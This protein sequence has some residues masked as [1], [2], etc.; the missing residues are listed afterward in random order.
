MAD[1]T[2][3]FESALLETGWA[4]EVRISVRDGAI[5]AIDVGVRRATHEAAN[6]PALPGLPNL[7]SHAFQRG[8]AGL[9]EHRGASADSFW[10]WREVMYRFLEQLGP[11]EVQAIAA[12]AYAEMLEAGFTRV[13]EFHYLHHD[14]DGRA[15]SNPAEM[16]VRIAAAAAEAGLGLT[17]L[18]VFY[19]HS[20]FGGLPPTDGQARFIHDVDGFA[21]LFEASRAA[22]AGLDG[23]VVGVAPHSLR[24]ATPQQIHTL[25]ELAGDAPIHIHIAEQ[26]KEV[27]DCQAWSGARPVEWLLANLD[28]GPQWC[29]VHATHI[30]PDE[31]AGI[32][33]SG[34]VAG[35]CPITEANLGDGLFPAMEF[36]AQGGRLG[37]GSDSNVLIDA[38]EELRLLEYGQRLSRRS[39]NVL[40]AEAGG[41]TGAA[42]YQAALAGGAQAL[43]VEVGLKVGMSADIVS[44]ASDHPVIA[45]RAG[46]AILDSYIFAGRRDL[47]DGV[48]RAGAKLVTSGRHRSREEISAR[49]RQVLVKVL[50]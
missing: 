18:P 29:L 23:A 47:I 44:L 42:L 50:S 4:R 31:T 37:V 32:A 11:D 48:W 3:W 25:A 6:G 33:R 36:R 15:F 24:A 1:E 30:T 13:G 16:A 7:H 39:R 46:D 19:A 34:A 28:V 35:L 43:G 26:A 14:L 40:A 2:I 49:Y 10:T 12:Q 41:S 21:R 9:A 20:G 27:A 22:V 17:L 8:M 5:A 38:A 45:G